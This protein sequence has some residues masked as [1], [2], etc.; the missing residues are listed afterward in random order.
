[1][2]FKTVADFHHGWWTTGSFVARLCNRFYFLGPNELD[3][4]MGGIIWSMGPRWSKQSGGGSAAASAPDLLGY[5][6][7][8]FCYLAHRATLPNGQFPS[9]R[10]GQRKPPHRIWIQQTDADSS[11]SPPP[12]GQRSGSE[13]HSSGGGRPGVCCHLLHIVVRSP[14]FLLP[15]VS[16]VTSGQKYTGHSAC[17]TISSNVNLASGDIKTG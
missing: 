5:S 6:S 7:R 13:L 4:V 3:Q 9:Q 10:R 8:M 15:W 1:M 12:S 2:L 14:V 17:L 11:S 16:L